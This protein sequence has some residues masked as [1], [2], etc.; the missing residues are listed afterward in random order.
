MPPFVKYFCAAVPTTR[1]LLVTLFLYQSQ[2]S[3]YAP[4]PTSSPQAP[5]M[6]APHSFGASRYEI[7][8]E[9]APYLSSVSA[10]SQKAGVIGGLQSPV[11]RRT[12]HASVASGEDSQTFSII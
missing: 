9:S 6:H 12:L 5:P 8:N 11:S 2:G 4:M 10:E 7:S 1:S 3:S